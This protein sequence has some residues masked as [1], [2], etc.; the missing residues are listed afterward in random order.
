M[1]NIEE[2]REASVGRLMLKYFIPAFVGVFVNA[3]HN[4]VD[5]I[6][7]GQGVGAEALSGVSVIF[8]IM[9]V[10]MGFG[11]LI[12]IGTGVY[13]SINM[14][15]KQMDRAEQTLGTGFVL[16][17]IVS[18]LFTVVTYIFKVPIL[19]SFGSTQETFQYAND[20]LDIVVAGTI[21]MIVGFSLNNVIR[22]EGNARI[23]MISMLLSSVTNLIL[24]P[25]FIFGLGM[26]VKGAAYAT[27]ISM[28]VL[29]AWVLFHFLWSKRAI[30]K[31]RLKNLGIDWRIVWEIIAIGMAPFSMQIASSFVQGLLNKQ[32]IG[33]GGDLAVGAMGIINSVVSLVVMA[34][35]A[36]NMAS[37]PIIGFNY[38]AKS[39][40][41]IKDALRISLIA[42][43]LISTG[44]FV[45]I[46]LFPG[47]IIRVFNNDSQTL[48]EI[49]SRG[50]RIFVMAFPFVGYQVVA[51]NFFQAIGK[52]GLSMFATLFRQLFALLP[53]LFIMPG[54]FKI[55]G[56]WM[57]FP[58]SDILAAIVVA[59]LLYREW[60]RLPEIEK[61]T[62]E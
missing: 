16:M 21:F 35:V 23:A 33:F 24:D 55:D 8:P 54:F 36:L 28:F 57:S 5:R 48:Y 1:N 11:M 34:I 46:E 47:L 19:L 15:R 45:F 37:Q 42:A 52:A 49:A 25:I 58:I 44:A 32:L 18:V 4:I 2:L 41:R 17:I 38:G 61:N 14:G 56:I 29:M 6:F 43:T 30:I 7:I 60:K 12:G 59:F 22:S 62:A 31:L 20:Y 13:V 53:L 3:L 51:S 26:G 9:L 40:E 50:L 39:V 27:V 10:M